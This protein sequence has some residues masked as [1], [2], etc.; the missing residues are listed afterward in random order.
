MS[1][2]VITVTHCL[3]RAGTWKAGVFAVY[4]EYGTRSAR[5]TGG[6][7]SLPGGLQKRPPQYV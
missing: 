4:T 5:A 7:S 1:C 2:D 3:D 6:S